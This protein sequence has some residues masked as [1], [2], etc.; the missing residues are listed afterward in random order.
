MLH[1][2]LLRHFAKTRSGGVAAL[3]RGLPRSPFAVSMNDG[4]PCIAWAVAD[5]RADNAEIGRE[6]LRQMDLEILAF[7]LP[8]WV[9]VASRS[10]VRIVEDMAGT[11]LVA[12]TVAVAA[13]GF[14]YCKLVVDLIVVFPVVEKE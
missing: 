11:A 13:A 5:S 9:S 2:S 3:R 8:R 4:V 10:L 6:W 14:E 1:C 12:D 7:A